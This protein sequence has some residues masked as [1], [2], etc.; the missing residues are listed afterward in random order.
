[1]TALSRAVHGRLFRL[2]LRRRR[3]GG[4]GGRGGGGRGGGDLLDLIVQRGEQLLLRVR[5]LAERGDGLLQL[6]A[7][8]IGHRDE[9]DGG[10]GGGVGAWVLLDDLRERL[11]RLAVLTRGHL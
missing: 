8:L 3:L 10:R 9:R 2:R 6:L 11:P 5:G 4:E 1:M 7:L